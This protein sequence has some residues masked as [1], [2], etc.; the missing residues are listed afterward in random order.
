M[1]QSHGAFKVNSARVARAVKGNRSAGP[2][3]ARAPGPNDQKACKKFS[4]IAAF[5][6]KIDRLPPKHTFTQS[7]K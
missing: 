7:K 2:R 1:E 5:A 4:Q 3:G 6:Q